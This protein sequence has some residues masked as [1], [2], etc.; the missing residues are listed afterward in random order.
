MLCTVVVPI[1]WSRGYAQQQQ[2]GFKSGISGK[3][4]DPK[5]T[6]LIAA[7]DA[8]RIGNTSHLVLACGLPLKTMWRPRNQNL[9]MY[10]EDELLQFD[11]MGQGV[12]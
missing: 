4:R 6:D 2:K 1:F 9:I 7:K 12:P 8:R 11:F 5:N 3:R 10:K